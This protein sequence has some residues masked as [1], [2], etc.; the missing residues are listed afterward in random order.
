M[1]TKGIVA[2]EKHNMPKYTNNTS[3]RSNTCNQKR[4][5]TQNASK[6]PV[7]PHPLRTQFVL[8]EVQSVYYFPNLLHL[9][10]CCAG[11]TQCNLRSHRRRA[12]APCLITQRT[13]RPVTSDSQLLQCIGI[14]KHHGQTPFDFINRLL[15]SA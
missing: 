3:I 9:D 15:A 12:R 4:R 1:T 10:G 7:W 11:P 2:K 5:N 8:S 13:I 14:A 6:R